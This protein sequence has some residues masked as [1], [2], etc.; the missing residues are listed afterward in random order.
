MVARNSSDFVC[1][2]CA[3]VLWTAFKNDAQIVGGHW[4]GLYQGKTA[5]LRQVCDLGDVPYAPPSVLRSQPSIEVFVALSGVT[6]V[7][8]VRTVEVE[9][10]ARPEGALCA[11]QEA[12][13]GCSR[14]K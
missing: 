3:Q 10:A 9:N 6:T 13:S 4:Y 5:T 2:A 12:F 7:D 8:Q 14:R 1:W 11:T